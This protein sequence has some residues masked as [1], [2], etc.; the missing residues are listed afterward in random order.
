MLKNLRIDRMPAHIADLD[1]HIRSIGEVVPVGG[2]YMGMGLTMEGTDSVAALT[3]DRLYGMLIWV[4]RDM[5]FDRIACDVTIQ[6]GQKIRM[7][8]FNVSAT[9]LLPSSLVVDAGEITLSGTGPQPITLSPVQ[10]LTRGIYCVAVVSNGTPTLRYVLRGFTP[11]G[12]RATHFGYPYYQVYASHS[13]AALPD[14]FGTIVNNHR[15]GYMVLLR[16]S[17]LD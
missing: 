13:Y 8:I 9:T 17:S 2:N 3:A 1:A 5:S 16:P 14:P 10:S 4:P 11:L 7:G 6:A 15:T 12:I